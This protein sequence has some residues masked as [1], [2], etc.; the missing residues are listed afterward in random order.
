MPNTVRATYD[1]TNKNGK[2]YRYNYVITV[3]SGLTLRNPKMI[4][5]L[6][7][8]AQGCHV[9]WHNGRTLGF[10]KETSLGVFSCRN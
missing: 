8:H 7:P 1:I 9:Y 3:I 4:L 10:G 2:S 5:A 6:Y